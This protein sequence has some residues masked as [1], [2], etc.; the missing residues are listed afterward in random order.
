MAK[1]KPTKPEEKIDSQQARMQAILDKNGHFN[2]I[3]PQS[4]EIS[5]GSLKFDLQLGGGLHNTIVRCAGPAE[6]GKTSFSLN[7]TKIFLQEPNRRGVYFLSDKDLS[8]NL[9]ERCGVKFVD[10]LEDWEDGTCYIIRTREYETVCNTIKG[11]IGSGGKY[12]TDKQYIFVLDSMDNFAPRAAFDVDFGESS[13]KGGITAIT[14]HFFKCFNILLPRLGHTTIMISQ[15]RDTVQIGKQQAAWK[16]MKTSGGRSLEHAASWAFEFLPIQN[17]QV[18]MFWDGE[19][20]KSKKIGH[21]CIIRLQKTTNETTGETV[22]YPIIYGREAG[23]SIWVEK[24]LYDLGL[25]YQML[26]SK[27][28]WIEFDSSV[29]KEIR[30]IN[31]DFPEKIQGEDKCVKLFE[32]NPKVSQFLYTKIKKLVAGGILQ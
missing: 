29:L 12:F 7:V 17:G 25:F 27:G 4:Y 30:E 3:E 10:K 13:Q 31:P 1:E 5:T 8:E 6:A 18:D 15:F 14:S 23:N 26:K 19:M 2:D 9:L 20:Y 28:S 16:Q 21:N 32:A 22:R 24:E 11:L